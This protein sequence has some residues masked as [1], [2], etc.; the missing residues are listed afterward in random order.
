MIT[1]YHNPRCRKSR[2][3]NIYLDDT[4]KDVEVINYM[5]TPFSEEKLKE[6]IDLLQIEPIELVRKNE[7]VWKE[8][9]KGKQLS[10]DAIVKAMVD[11]P[12]L[13]ERPIVINGN[14]AV[15]ARPLEKVDSI[16]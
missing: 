7:K 8:S 2:E 11:N 1:I 10:N 12:K 3:C 5:E 16:L 13:I 9:F 15:I 4:G 14:K 6:I